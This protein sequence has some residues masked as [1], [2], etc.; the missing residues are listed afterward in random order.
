LQHHRQ[1]A[2]V[3]CSPVASK[4]VQFAFVRFFRRFLSQIDQAVRHAR[5]GRQDD[6]H[7]VAL[8]IGF[9]HPLRHTADA[10]DIGNRCAAEFLNHKSHG[11][12]FTQRKPALS[13][14]LNNEKSNTG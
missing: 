5:H 6:H 10:F 8:I 11:C 7:S 12:S 14:N 2:A 13:V 4:H 9:G 3:V 1:Q